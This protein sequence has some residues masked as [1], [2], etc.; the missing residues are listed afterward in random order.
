M[1]QKEEEKVNIVKV[2]REKKVWH[3]KNSLR[4]RKDIYQTQKIE[5]IAYKEMKLQYQI[6]TPE[7]N[8][9]FS[10]EMEIQ[11]RKRERR[12]ILL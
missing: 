11:F 10:K 7:R 12:C 6:S 5:K 4:R 8:I 3:W 2:K 1:L 9:H